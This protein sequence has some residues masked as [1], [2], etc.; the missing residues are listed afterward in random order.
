MSPEVWGRLPSRRREGALRGGGPARPAGSSPWSFLRPRASEAWQAGRLPTASKASRRRPARRNLGHT[1]CLGAGGGRGTPSPPPSTSPDAG[2]FH[3]APARGKPLSAPQTTSFEA[4]GRGGRGGGEKPRDVRR[5]PAGPPAPPAARSPVPAALAPAPA[6]QQR[7]GA[8][9]QPRTPGPGAAWAGVQR[10]GRGDACG[11]PPPGPSGGPAPEALGRL[12]CP[13]GEV[14]SA[15]GRGR[16]GGR[17]VCTRSLRPSPFLSWGWG[18]RGSI[19]FCPGVSAARS[20][21]GARLLSPPL[22]RGCGPT[23]AG[24]AARAGQWSVRLRREGTPTP[25]LSAGRCPARAA[26]R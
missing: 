13:S 11:P 8:W 22:P 16:A 1:A 25:Q 14:V 9:P 4:A 7:R 10:G 23:C 17:A 15:A 26:A 21:R 19:S 5:P 6:R 24:G 3:P 18:G 2:P 20:A 12:P